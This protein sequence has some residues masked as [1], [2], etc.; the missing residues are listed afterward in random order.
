MGRIRHEVHSV[1]HYRFSCECE[2][3]HL[4]IESTQWLIAF[5]HSCLEG[6]S[7]VH[8]DFLAKQ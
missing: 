5:G 3:L 7:G 2:T 8:S 4:R 1:F 6:I